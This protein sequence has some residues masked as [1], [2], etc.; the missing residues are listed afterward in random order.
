MLKVSV[1][2]VN[3]V[4]KVDGDFLIQV[5]D[6]ASNFKTKEMIDGGSLP[7][8]SVKQSGK[9]RHWLVKQHKDKFGIEQAIFP[10]VSSMISFY[11]ESQ[12][13]IVKGETVIIKCA[14]LP[15]SEGMEGCG[16]KACSESRQSMNRT[17]SAVPKRILTLRWKLFGLAVDTSSS[18]DITASAFRL[19]DMGISEG[20]LGSASAETQ[21]F[22]SRSVC[23]TSSDS[24]LV[25]SAPA[26]VSVGSSV[27]MRTLGS[28]Q[29]RCAACSPTFNQDYALTKAESKYV[30]CA[31]LST[32]PT[33]NSSPL[34]LSYVDKLELR[35]NI[36]KASSF[37]EFVRLH[38][39]SNEN[40]APSMS[41]MIRLAELL[42]EDYKQHAIDSL[43]LGTNV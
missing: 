36:A 41:S 7:V 28:I 22:K 25:N 42:F 23:N 40:C 13:S 35:Y 43:Q 9:V 2:Q 1:A 4:L 21:L 15:K 26:E 14:V 18:L 29:H 27:M 38:G 31:S 3:S 32:V 20:D 39:A 16:K 17:V 30:N 19:F 24:H 11:L 33:A 10:S 12:R 8:L 37:Y 34:N 6:Q 5:V